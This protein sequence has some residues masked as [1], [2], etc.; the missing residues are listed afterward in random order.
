MGSEPLPDAL[1]S[2]ISHM[3]HKANG[4]LNLF[5]FLSFSDSAPLSGN[6]NERRTGLTCSIDMRTMHYTPSAPLQTFQQFLTNFL[7]L[8]NGA[9][10]RPA[11]RIPFFCAGF[12]KNFRSQSPSGNFFMIY[13]E[14]SPFASPLGRLGSFP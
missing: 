7:R 13:V 6:M 11:L 14:C 2:D 3:L 9:K 4:Q 5:V 8:E 10:P 1:I 12:C